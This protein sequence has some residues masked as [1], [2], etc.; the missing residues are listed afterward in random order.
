VG[1]E[2]CS[3]QN[4]VHEILTAVRNI[5]RL[6]AI[7]AGF[8][9]VLPGAVHAQAQG[10]A[11]SSGSIYDGQWSFEY[12]NATQ[13]GGTRAQS[14]GYVVTQNIL[15]SAVKSRFQVDRNG[16]FSWIE[17]D[18]TYYHADSF[19]LNKDGTTASLSWDQEAV[20][21]ATGQVVDEKTRTLKV[22]VDHWEGSG[23]FMDRMGGG[24]ITASADGHTQTYFP[25]GR[26]TAS[27]QIRHRPVVWELKPVSIERQDLGPDQQREIVTYKASRG[28]K[29]PVVLHILGDGNLSTIHI[30]IR[31]V[32]E[33]KLVPRG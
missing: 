10:P 13:P 20:L 33:L 31:Q 16:V 32:R 5:F 30:E 17:R 27:M 25:S 8:G 3:G 2:G 7:A 28:V 19:Y 4:Q 6:A 29:P 12:R 22:T 15:F 9:C 23:R 18:N 24:T 14:A 26:P 21:K 11:P 1:Q